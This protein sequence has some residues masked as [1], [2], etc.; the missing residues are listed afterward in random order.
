[1]SVIR[2][3]AQ[4]RILNVIR[5]R[6][7]DCDVLRCNRYFTDNGWI[8]D[9]F[10]LKKMLNSKPNFAKMLK[11]QSIFIEFKIENTRDP[12]AKCLRGYKEVH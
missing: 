7:G 11:E 6:N 8:T 3:F 9:R 5:V 4:N 12:L 10:G 2:S 1:M